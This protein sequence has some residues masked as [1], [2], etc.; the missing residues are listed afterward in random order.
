MLRH[1]RKAVEPEMPLAFKKAEVHLPQF[2]KSE[3]FHCIK[4]LFK[5]IFFL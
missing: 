2:V 1:K 3:F 5:L 4:L